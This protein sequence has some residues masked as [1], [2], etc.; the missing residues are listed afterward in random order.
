MKGGLGNIFVS[1]LYLMVPGSQVNIQK[2]FGSSHLVEQI[3][4]P[5]ELVTIL[6]GHFV[7]LMVVNAH[8]NHTV[9]LLY[10]KNWCS[11]RRHTES[12][13]PFLY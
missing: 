7:Q 9:L 1:D 3:I 8:S 2:Y 4:D 5:R 10:E 13:V 11:P 6:Y 12:D